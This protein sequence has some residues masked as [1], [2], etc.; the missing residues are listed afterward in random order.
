VID[1]VHKWA[2]MSGVSDY[3]ASNRNGQPLY[4][5]DM[6]EGIEYIPTDDDGSQVPDF[7]IEDLDTPDP[8][9]PDYE[10]Y[11]ETYD[12]ELQEMES[13]DGDEV[14]DLQQE[15]AAINRFEESDP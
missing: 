4:Q 5:A 8:E 6:R 12:E 3:Q 14:N 15:T 13:V 9:D 1:I 2:E 7:D 11:I 10:D